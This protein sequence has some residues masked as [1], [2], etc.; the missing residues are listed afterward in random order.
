[1][2]V[3]AV[4]RCR[5]LMAAGPDM[6]L[7]SSMAG[8]AADPSDDCLGSL[9]G[10][11]PDVPASTISTTLRSIGAGCRSPVGSYTGTRSSF[12]SMLN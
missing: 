4:N 12:V 7:A 8:L 1:M 11:A 5:L 6:G 9:G 2:A 10:D 3:P